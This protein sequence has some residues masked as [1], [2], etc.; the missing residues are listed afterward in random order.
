M[1]CKAFP[2]WLKSTC[3]STSSSSSVFQCSAFLVQHSF[4]AAQS[5]LMY[6]A[7]YFSEACS[8]IWFSTQWISSAVHF[9]GFLVQCS[10]ADGS[11]R[12]SI[13]VTGH[14]REPSALLQNITNTFQGK[15][16]KYIK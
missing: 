5:L 8:V 15:V 16:Q 12:D 6:H 13:G 11:D 14:Q 7:V 3:F 10:A 9:S 2:H 4:S 1:T